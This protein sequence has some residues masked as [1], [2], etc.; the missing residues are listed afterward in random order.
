MPIDF[1]HIDRFLREKDLQN[2][3]LKVLIPDMN[4]YKTLAY[5][6]KGEVEASRS[7]DLFIRNQNRTLIVSQFDAF[8]EKALAEE[9][10][11]AI[12]PE[13]SCPWESRS[14]PHSLDTFS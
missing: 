7:D 14:G 11:L 10:D 4:Q 5:Q 12:T 9:V 13:Y 1:E 2:P 3:T 6:H 8:F